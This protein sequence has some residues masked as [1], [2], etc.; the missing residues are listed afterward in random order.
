MSD[1]KI[2]VEKTHGLSFI[3]VFCLIM[4]IFAPE[5]LGESAAKIK[6]GY[7]NYI[8]EQAPKDNP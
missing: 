5:K 8:A 1:T 6:T 7:D 2:T 4:F 3:F